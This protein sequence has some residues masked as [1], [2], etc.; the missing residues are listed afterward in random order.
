MWC[1]VNIAE[2][3]AGQYCRKRLMNIIAMFSIFS[4]I[5]ISC[6]GDSGT[7]EIS[8][9]VSLPEYI[10][11]NLNV[12]VA[13]GEDRL[14]SIPDCEKVRTLRIIIVDKATGKIEYNELQAGV[15]NLRPGNPY[16]TKVK[17]L[18]G[19]KAVKTVYALANVEDIISDELKTTFLP[20]EELYQKLNSYVLSGDNTDQINANG[21][22]P[23]TS[24]ANDIEFTVDKITHTHEGDDIYSYTINLVY[25]AVKFNVSFTN[26][27]NEDVDIVQWQI[28]RLARRSY[29]MPH[30]G[31]EDWNLI[32]SLAGTVDDT[33]W[34]KDYSVPAPD[35]LSFYINKY[36]EANPLNKNGGTYKDEKSYYF[37]E[38]KNPDITDPD[39]QTDNK[40]QLYTLTLGIRQKTA[41]PKSDPI[42]MTGTFDNLKSLVRGTHV[43]INARFSKLP[44]AGK[45]ELE[46]RVVDWIEHDPIEGGW[47]NVTGK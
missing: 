9:N 27:S 39:S 17:V 40:E 32:V 5:M 18:F 47:E 6:S 19:N 35:G 20:G 4:C 2:N 28:S 33:R 7:E 1:K 37:H 12:Q 21:S 31:P 42:L 29:L 25:A 45:N 22:L 10:Y 8:D 14:E 23:M 41:D 46:V 3:A 36:P 13:Y 15:G 24:I 43:V 34:V 26:N 44:D 38:T 11:L 30:V 16:N